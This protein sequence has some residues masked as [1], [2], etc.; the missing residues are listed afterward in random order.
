M[1][2]HTDLGRVGTV[3][4]REGD[5]RPLH[6]LPSQITKVTKSR[7]MGPGKLSAMKYVLHTRGGSRP[8][9]P[10]VDHQRGDGASVQR[11]HGV[12]F[13]VSGDQIRGPGAAARCCV[14]RVGARAG[15][16][17]VNAPA[18]FRW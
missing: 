9:V 3:R 18:V 15:Q 17:P 13:A 2:I 6:R 14:R 10:R 16:D 5:R 7:V 8:T 12:D 1:G 11:L 4:G